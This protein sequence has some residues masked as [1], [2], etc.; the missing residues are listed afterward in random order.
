MSLSRLQLFNT[1]GIVKSGPDLNAITEQAY[2]VDEE[3][4]Y[5]E[6]LNNAPHGNPWHTSF[7]ASSFPG[8][9]DPSCARKA[10]YTLMDI[11]YDAATSSRL[12]GQAEV[13]QAIESQVVWRWMKQGWMLGEKGHMEAPKSWRSYMPQLGLVDPDT[14]LT[15]SVD[16]ALD[17]RPRYDRV[18][19]VDLK[20]KSE[21]VIKEMQTG[22][23]DYLQ[24]D[25]AQVQTYIYL[26][27]KNWDNLPW[28]SMGLKKPTH[29]AIFYMS[30]DNPRGSN[31]QAYF[32]YDAE[33]VQAGIDR[34]VEWQQ[35][36]IDD[37]LPPRPP[38]W[39]WTEE[40][41]KWCVFKKHCKKDVKDD[42]NRL[43]RSHAI[44]FAKSI[45][46]NY[47]PA[48]KRKEVLDR[49]QTS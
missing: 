33:Y 1:L 12:R 43:S 13:G 19:P 3:K 49:W 34:L 36:F 38:E 15:G 7:H 35:L 47:D 22:L 29:G 10:L 17:I 45:R 41:C 44:K 5:R 8:G 23:R 27:L 14:W 4:V 48:Q 30:R 21:A 42:I 2:L 26:I 31:W 16:A 9:D 25:Y 32:P 28:E 18:L 6:N 39:K 40:P 46:P 37:K 24:K 11:P 20:T